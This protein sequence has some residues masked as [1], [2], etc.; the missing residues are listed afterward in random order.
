[1]MRVLYVED[2]EDNVYMLKMRLELLEGF[3]I[4]VAKDGAEAISRVAAD[5]PDIILM[6]LNVPVLNGWDATRRLK[7]DASTARIP[8]IALTAHAMASDRDKALA[9]GCDDFD[10]K[11]ID[12]ER[13][14][15]KMRRLLSVT[16]P[17]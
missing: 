17:S 13:L 7:A 11:P 12:F 10:T 9:A 1:M 16:A 3:E 8:I 14:I 15:A 2:N 6:D 4:A 5:P